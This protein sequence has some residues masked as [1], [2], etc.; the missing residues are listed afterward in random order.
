M[1]DKISIAVVLIIC[2]TSM[3]AK[4]TKSKNPLDTMLKNSH[5]KI[6][7]DWS[8][9]AACSVMVAMFFDSMD[10][11][12]GINY[13]GFVHNYRQEVFYHKY[14]F[15]TMEELLDASWYKFKVV[16]NPYA[17]LVSSYMQ[18]MLTYL[19]GEIFEHNATLQHD[20]TFEQ[21]VSIYNTEW[22]GKSRSFSGLDHVD[23][24]VSEIEWKAYRNNDRLFNKIV[25]LEYFN[26]DIAK[27][28]RD[29]GMNYTL[30]KYHDDHNSAHNDVD[31]TIISYGK[32]PF[33]FFSKEVGKVAY[34]SSYKVFYDPA[35]RDV[36]KN[37][38][39]RDLILYGYTY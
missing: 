18:V 37:I 21:F 34:P 20:A 5:R 32:L 12:Q 25:R 31:P 27:V 38:F 8:P 9:K 19:K 23:P 14:G 16:R 26:T 1:L 11:R 10:I 39:K 33:S 35:L 30:G 3:S 4:I 22:F 28:N 2:Y 36:V 17:R 13:T 6:I 24:Q 15:V 29:T 7:M